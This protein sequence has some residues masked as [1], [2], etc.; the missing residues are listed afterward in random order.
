MTFDV[1]VTPSR[2]T[3]VAFKS[4]EVMHYWLSSNLLPTLLP[5]HFLFNQITTITSKISMMI[6]NQK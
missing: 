3:M 6:F 4:Y 1:S 5:L 2:S